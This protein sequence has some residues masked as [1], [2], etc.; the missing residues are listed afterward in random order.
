MG[1]MCDELLNLIFNRITKL[2]K[3]KNFGLFS[4]TLDTHH[5]NGYISASCKNTK[6][7]DGTN[8]ILNSLHCVDQLIGKFMDAYLSSDIYKI[9]L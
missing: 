1:N 4:L 7:L 8:P 5:P 6:Y 2:I 3:K 9:L